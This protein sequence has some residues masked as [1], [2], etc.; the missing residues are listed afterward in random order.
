MINLLIFLFIFKLNVCNKSE[1]YFQKEN[2][3]ISNV[4]GRN[5]TTSNISKNLTKKNVI[6]GIIQNFPLQKILP[7]FK[8]WLKAGFENC[9]MIMFVRYV[10][11]EIINYLRSIGVIVFQIPEKYKNISVINLR[12]KMYSDYLKDNKNKYNL[13]LHTD[14]R[15]TFFQKDVFKYYEDYEPFLGVAIEDGTLE[16]KLN[17]QWI[18]DY[19]G[20]KKHRK[21][22]NERI[23]CVGQIWGTSDK[24][25]EFSSIFWEKLQANPNA[26]E[27]GIGNYLIYYEKVLKD[28]IIKSDNFG[29]IMTI[30]LTKPNIIH[31]DSNNNVLNFRD[32]IASVIHQYDRK[33]DIVNIVINKF[34]P[35]LMISNQKL[36][37]SISNVNNPL[38]KNNSIEYNDT[39]KTFRNI[40]YNKDIKNI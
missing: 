20:E 25:L 18:I 38:I 9:E 2:I 16:E 4:D 7:F 19:A 35:E 30:G 11:P 15:D 14:V 36:N 27:Q 40:L 21:I 10:T 23:I 34:C 1:L 8:S 12:W 17:K 37:K 3:N 33:K 24:F 5:D 28:Y 22:R 29:P 39:N 31:L 13:V 32:E 26:I 6:L